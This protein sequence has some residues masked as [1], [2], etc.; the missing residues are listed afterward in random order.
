MYGPFAYDC[1]GMLYHALSII[2][3]L[4][5]RGE[6]LVELDLAAVSYLGIYHHACAIKYHP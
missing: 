3:S 1:V 6:E 4:F 2:L 5:S